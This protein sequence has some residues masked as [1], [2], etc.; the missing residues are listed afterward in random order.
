MNKEI[1]VYLATGYSSYADFLEDYILVDNIKEA[2]L[3]IFEGGEDINPALYHEPVGRYTYFNNRRD[4]LELHVY[5][6]AREL[7]IPCWGTCR[8]LQFLTAMAGGRLIQDMTHTGSHEL[9]FYD[10][11]KM[12]TNTLH[13]QMAYPYDLKKGEDY[14]LL[15]AAYG[16]SNTFEDGYHR[17]IEMP[18]VDGKTEEPEMIYYPKINAIGIQGHPEMMDNKSTMVKVCRAFVSLLL[19]GSLKENLDLGLGIEEILAL[20]S[21]S[22]KVEEDATS[23]ITE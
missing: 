11:F 1:K 16:L 10:G 17:Q 4:A 3:V 13:H 18:I 9:T 12:R 8:G 7:N 15:A 20:A 21:I 22:D 2:D 5:E 19:E 23:S 6:Q 14:Y